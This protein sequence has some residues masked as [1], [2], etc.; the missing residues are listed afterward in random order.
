ML[1]QLFTGQ[2]LLFSVPAMLGS[3][4]FLM[5]LGLM[6]LGG[7]VDADVEADV[8]VDADVDTADASGHA[9]TFLS[10]QSIAAFLMGFGWGGLVGLLTL[11]W[12][13]VPSAGLGIAFGAFLVWLLGILLRAVHEL[14][15][16]GHVLIEDAAGCR[17][18][19]YT[20][21]PQRAGGAGQVRVVI[22]DRERYFNATSI[23]EPLP[24]GTAVRVVYV[25][26]DRSLMVTRI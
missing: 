20:A 12:Q 17:G 14:Q 25:N 4:V 8:D 7:A 11:E 9:F 24:T 5:K 21:V 1:D 22:G 19:V 10:V 15:G 13:I 6:L 23:D 3:L 2:S 16:S 18:T 26:E